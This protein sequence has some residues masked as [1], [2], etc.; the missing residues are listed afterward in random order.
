MNINKTVRIG[1]TSTYGGRGMSI[2][3][4]IKF[5]DSRL[6]IT[7][8][9]GP[10]P[11]GNCLGSCGQIDTGLNPADFNTYAPGWNVGLLRRF[12]DVWDNWHLNDMN[13][14]TPAQTAELD[15]HEFPNDSARP[16]Y[17][18]AKDNL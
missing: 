4:R 16:H 6:S 2:Y 17:R 12:L 7:G 10:L 9:E 15:K 18:W 11:S 14:G 5:N 8:V 13:A 1:T 3:C